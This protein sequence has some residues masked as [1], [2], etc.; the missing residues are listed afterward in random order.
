[1]IKDY[2]KV[3]GVNR[4]DEQDKIKSAYNTLAKKYH[5][6]K[7]PNNKDAEDTFKSIAEA[8]DVLSDPE[9]K[10]KFDNETSF[11]RQFDTFRTV[12]SHNSPQ[13]D[14]NIKFVKKDRPAG[15]NLK[16]TLK[17]TLEEIYEGTTK[18]VSIKRLAAC[19]T[20]DSSGAKTTK[21]CILCDGKGKVLT[22]PKGTGVHVLFKNMETCPNC[23]GSYVEPNEVCITCNGTG[24][25]QIQSELKI[26][27]QPG[28]D[29]YSTL[30]KQG[31]GNVGERGGRAGDLFISIEQIEHEVFIRDGLDL[32]VNCPLN[33]TDLVL[34]TNIKVPTLNG[35]IEIKIPS[36]TDSDTKF[37]IKNK[38]LGKEVHNQ[39]PEIGNLYATV[40]VIIPKN[41]NEEQIELFESLKKIE[42]SVKF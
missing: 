15:D 22:I 36:G 3:L 18:T 9:K 7:N 6:D 17:L 39:D 10:K 1:M 14:L 26:Q 38:G 27:I 24:T 12:F 19:G 23:F 13:E 20:C 16:L 42:D 32:Y 29:N 11:T 40:K 34:G 4:T 30:T 41:L 37:R 35:E 5:P 31:F 21:R 28:I 2:Y 25:N 33:I 8:Y